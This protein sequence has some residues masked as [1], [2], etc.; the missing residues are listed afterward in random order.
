MNWCPEAYVHVFFRA[1]YPDSRLVVRR[2]RG[3]RVTDE[4]FLEILYSLS[5]YQHPQRVVGFEGEIRG[6]DHRFPQSPGRSCGSFL[7]DRRS[8][9]RRDW[10]FSYGVVPPRFFIL[11]W[12]LAWDL[13]FLPSEMKYLVLTNLF[14]MAIDLRAWF[15][16]S[17]SWRRSRGS[18]PHST[19]RDEALVPF[20]PPQQIFSAWYWTLSYVS[21]ICLHPRSITSQ[22]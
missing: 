21:V 17:F 3:V 18:S 14:L 15:A 20:M 7:F 12:S 13:D 8:A 19:C 11:K 5:C 2:L 9:S 6:V 22:P 1:I 4:T 16:M 10:T